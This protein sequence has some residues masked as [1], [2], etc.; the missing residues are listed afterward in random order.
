[1]P[2]L[3]RNEKENKNPKLV[4]GE[5]F[6]LSKDYNNHKAGEFFVVGMSQVIWMNTSTWSGYLREMQELAEF[7]IATLKEV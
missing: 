7:K 1:M 5:V 4:I 3:G 2:I 6:K